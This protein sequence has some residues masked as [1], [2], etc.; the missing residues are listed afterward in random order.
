MKRLIGCILTLLLLAGCGG[1]GTDWS[2]YA[3]PEAARLTV[4]TSHEEAV[5]APVVKEFEERTGL[6][7]Q[8]ETGSGLALLE[9][10]AGE[11][12][13]PVCDLLLSGSV[14]I[15]QAN[16]ELFE[17]YVSPETANLD[18]GCQC[19]DGTW[20]AF[21]LLPAVMI[22]NPILVRNNPPEGWESL[23]DPAW[24]GRIAFPEPVSSSSGYTA[25][26][27][28]LQVLPG[29]T[30]ETLD[31]FYRNLDGHVLA[32]PG[33]A[34][35]E[36]AEGSCMIGVT[37]EETALKAL[38]SHSDVALL[39]PEE[40][41]VCLPDGMAVVNG[42]PHRDNARL[43]IDFCLSEDV[44]NYLT[45]ISRR[46]VRRDVPGTLAAAEEFRRLDYDL[47]RAVRERE[48]VLSRWRQLEEGKP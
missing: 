8:V 46:P 17:P 39:Y 19:A 44:Q 36:V 38:E 16:S 7:V 4:Y 43:F 28:L 1:S 32:E 11:A 12:E 29:E 14:D 26:A 48:T 37:L 15:L 22:Y 45:S 42:A 20:T 5:Y 6:W 25:L 47:D 23:L 31:A 35:T 41:V 13:Q 24:R 30:P 10:I 2:G 34:V 21:S 18:E 27:A 9:K 3:P 33:D 40:G